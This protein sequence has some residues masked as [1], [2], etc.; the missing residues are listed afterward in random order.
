MVTTF[1]P[2]PS[3]RESLKILDTERLG[4]QR[5]EIKIILAALTGVRFKVW[6]G[7]YG[8]VLPEKRGYKNH[9][10]TRMWRGHEWA[11]AEFGRLNYQVW[12]NR[13]GHPIEKGSKGYD[14]LIDMVLWKQWLEERGASKEL[15]EWWGDEAVHSS[16]RSVL[17]SKDEEFYRKYG[18]TEPAEY[19]YVWPVD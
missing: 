6:R 16:H 2:V 11:L 12:A 1:V 8:V 10:V 13:F 7:E 17:L 4:K 3:V 9:S 14:T 5:S 15:P 19:K 18:W